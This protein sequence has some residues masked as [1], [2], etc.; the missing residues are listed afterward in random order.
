[1]NSNTKE[2]VIKILIYILVGFAVGFFW[3][4]YRNK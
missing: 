4:Q 3:H 2:R 1:M